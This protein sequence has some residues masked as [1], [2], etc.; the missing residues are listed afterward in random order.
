MNSAVGNGKWERR[1]C[2]WWGVVGS[3]VLLP[4]S[5]VERF[6]IRVYIQQLIVQYKNIVNS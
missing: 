6:L 4:K 2:L 1:S 3:T 5:G